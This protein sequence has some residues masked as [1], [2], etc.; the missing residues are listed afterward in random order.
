MKFG[1][2]GGPKRLDYGL[3]FGAGVELGPIVVSLNYELGLANI[4][5]S[6]DYTSKNKVLQL[7]LAYM[8][9]GLK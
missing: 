8:F 2:K 7:S 5:D 4:V 3:G 6:S 9:G 1:E